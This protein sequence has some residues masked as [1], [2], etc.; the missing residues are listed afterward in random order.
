MHFTK[1]IMNKELDV[2]ILKQH[3]KTSS[4]KLKER[5]FYMENDL[6]HLQTGLKTTKTRKENIFDLGI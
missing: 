4:R 1:Q 5:V 3:L 6:K 2:K